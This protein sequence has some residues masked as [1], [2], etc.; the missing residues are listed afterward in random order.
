ML[1]VIDGK[2]TIIIE[3]QIIPVV[4]GSTAVILP[5]MKHAVKAD[6]ELHIIE[7]QIGAELVETDIERLDWDW[8]QYDL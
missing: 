7:V 1:T 5:G 4:R 6:T 2:G 3:G 8:T